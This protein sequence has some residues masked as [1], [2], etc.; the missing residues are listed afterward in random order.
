MSNTTRNFTEIAEALQKDVPSEVEA[1]RLNLEHFFALVDQGSPV[2]EAFSSPMSVLSLVW[3]I[4][5]MVRN[6]KLSFLYER[7]EGPEFLTRIQTGKTKSES[8]VY[9][10]PSH[11][12][13]LE[14]GEFAPQAKLITEAIRNRRTFNT[15][16]FQNRE[17]RESLLRRFKLMQAFDDI[18]DK[19]IA[20]IGDDALFSVFLSLCGDAKEILVL[21]IDPTLV[22][23]ITEL[24]EELSL[25]NLQ[26]I[27]Y[28]VRNPLPEQI[29][30]SF[31]KFFASGFKD[32]GGLLLFI[33]RGL[34]CLN[35]DNPTRSGY[36]VFGNHVYDRIALSSYTFQIQ[37]W[38]TKFGCALDSIVP[39]VNTWMSDQ[40]IDALLDAIVQN[41]NKRTW[42]LA[43]EDT[44]ARILNLPGALPQEGW[45]QIPEYPLINLKPVPAARISPTQKMS[46]SLRR[47]LKM[48]GQGG[49]SS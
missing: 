26:A 11:L 43:W 49:F 35:E 17:S 46:V 30:G 14:E 31:D 9:S 15:D 12:A 1:T 13:S 44:K 22:S 21:D 42:A 5:M 2:R 4:L 34:E 40:Y 36:F 23:L 19:S 37:K 6:E 32:V 25:K 20:V 41:R 29:T 27:T 33:G 28:D 45:L 3:L 24:A 10:N 38:L 39:C 47:Y 8:V 7:D 18:E 48:V 16:F